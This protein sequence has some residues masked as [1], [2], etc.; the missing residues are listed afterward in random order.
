MKGILLFA[1]PIFIG[2]FFS[3]LYGLIDMR[4]VGSMLGEASLAAVSSTSSVSELIIELEDGIAVGFGVVLSHILA[5]KNQDKVKRAVALSSLIIIALSIVISGL[6]MIFINPILNFLNVEASLFEDAKIYIVITL[7]GVIF[8]AVYNLFVAILRSAGDSFTPLIFLIVSNVLNIILDVIFVRNMSL[9][10]SGA[11][12]ATAITQ[13]ICCV[14]CLVYFRIFKKDML[15]ILYDFVPD[16][17]LFKALVKKGLSMGGI[18]SFVLLG[19]V[20]LQT[21]VNGFGAGIIVAHTA[22]DKIIILCLMPILSVGSALYYFCEQNKEADE[23]GRIKKGI[24]QSILF[25]AVWCVISILVIYSFSEKIITSVTAVF[26]EEVVE[27]GMLYLKIDSI[28]FILSALVCIIRNCLQGVGDD[29][30]PLIT[31]VIELIVKVLLTYTL[32][33]WLGSFGVIIV[34]PIVWTVMIISLAVMLARKKLLMTTN[35][36]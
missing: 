10:V 32:V 23:S 8:L 21:A 14:G 25:S 22:A 12:W 15:I 11:A 27:D 24:K 19:S 6:V 17:E 33:V 26:S 9:G 29:K 30:T 34:E 36:T 20:V 18:I 16:M 7:I 1:L 2:E 3:I 4:I 28:F 5:S 13:F 35:R 31:N